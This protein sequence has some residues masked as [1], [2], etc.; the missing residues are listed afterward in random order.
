MKLMG[1]LAKAND[2]N[3]LLKTTGQLRP[4]LGGRSIR[5]GGKRASRR[6]GMLLACALAASALTALADGW[7][8]GRHH[9]LPQRSS[10][11]FAILSDLHVF[12]TR[13]GTSGAA[14]EAYLN[15]DPKLLRES[16]AIF[17][18][19][20]QSIVKQRVQFV[21]I[22]GDLTKDG[23]LVDHQLV[24]HHLARL[25]RQGIQVFVVPGNHDINNSDAV[26]FQGNTSS[27][28]PTVSPH[29]FRVL[30]ERFGYRQAIAR[31]EHSLSYVAEPAHGLWLLGIDSCK[32]EESQQR[33]YPVVG[34][35]IK[36]ETMTW[37]LGKL[38]E[39][40]TH[41]KQVIAFMHH[42]V[43]QHFLGEA[44]IFPDYLLDDWANV[45][46]QLAGAGLKVVFTG[47]Y[48]SQDAAYPLDA[49]GVPT[50]T[51]CDVETSS[52]AMSPCAFRVATLDAS[53]LSIASQQVTEIKADTGG[54]PFQ[55]Y[56]LNFLQA[57]LPALATY[58]LMTM[59]NL[60]QAQAAGAAPLVADAL[61]AN[62]AGDETPSAQTQGMLSGLV[63]STDPALHTLGLMLSG[64]WTDLPPSDNQL[65]LPFP[66]N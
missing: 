45:S 6:A 1:S 50:A 15:Q 44:Q 62:Y 26:A 49:N 25:E 40:K 5:N 46:A 41:H 24:A 19:A 34:G 51:L 63:Q 35:R 9:P 60:P 65:V 23:E 53:V 57:R 27:P 55:Q 29:D 59:F 28:V 33:G 36:A 7:L 48:H 38:Q 47:H 30:Y 12:D 21:L 32:Y 2:K 16:E 66:G 18:S 39:A 17:D 43:N 31:D 10:L 22:T 8:D 14:F 11:R 42:G 37:I 4:S 3:P 64:I 56:A 52:L 13:L 61:I 58:Q 54:V 20:L